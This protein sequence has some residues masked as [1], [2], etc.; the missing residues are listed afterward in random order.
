MKEGNPVFAYTAGQQLDATSTTV[1][2]GS[3]NDSYTEAVMEMQTILNLWK[4]VKP[5]VQVH[6]WI[7][8][9]CFSL[10]HVYSGSTLLFLT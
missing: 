5:S 1:Q 2:H 3:V 7:F 8:A 10:H 9:H 6:G 4:N